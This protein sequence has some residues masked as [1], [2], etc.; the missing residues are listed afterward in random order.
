VNNIIWQE[1]A[2]AELRAIEQQTALRILRALARMV[3]T[4]Q[5]DVKRLKDVD[6][7]ESRLRVSDY[8]LRYR[9]LSG[10]IEVLGVK[11]RRDAYR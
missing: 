9:E 2:K 11:H 5:G 7:P 4:G 3:A 6:P 10:G 1:A 8:R